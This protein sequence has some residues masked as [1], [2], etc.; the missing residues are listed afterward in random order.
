MRNDRRPH[1]FSCYCIPT[2]WM[3]LPTPPSNHPIDTTSQQ[4]EALSKGESNA[5]QS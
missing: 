1:G 5:S 4:Y 3:P 2:H